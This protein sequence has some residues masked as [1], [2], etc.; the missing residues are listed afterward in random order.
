MEGIDIDRTVIRQN[1][2]FFYER[3]SK[4]GNTAIKPFR[5]TVC[6]P[7]VKTD[8]FET[9]YVFDLNSNSAGQ[10]GGV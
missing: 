10:S 3:K 6:P 4:G 1:Q 2:D 9:S 8:D 5:V 7:I